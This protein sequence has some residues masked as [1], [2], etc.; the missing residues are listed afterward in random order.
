LGSSIAQGLPEGE[1]GRGLRPAQEEVKKAT[2]ERGDS[3][4]PVGISAVTNP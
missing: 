4:A 1:A 3:G 2:G